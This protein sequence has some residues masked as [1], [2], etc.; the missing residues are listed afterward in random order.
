MCSFGVGRGEGGHRLLRQHIDRTLEADTGSRVTVNTVIAN[1]TL[2]TQNVRGS[3]VESLRWSKC[4]APV[5]ST[6]NKRI[7]KEKKKIKL[8][9]CSVSFVKY[10]T[11]VHCSTNRK[12]THC[13]QL[14]FC[15]SKQLVLCQGKC[16]ATDCTC[17]DTDT[18]VYY[19]IL[20]YTIDLAEG[21]QLNVKYKLAL[22]RYKSRKSSVSIS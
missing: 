3:H 22:P 20:Y 9:I 14:Y 21:Y 4:I 15:S 18:I 5:S 13:R 17:K 12:I 2:R 6:R 16:S 11:R 1:T 7:R 10:Y 19:T 8:Y